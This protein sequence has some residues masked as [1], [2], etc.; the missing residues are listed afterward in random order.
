MKLGRFA[1][2]HRAG[3]RTVFVLAL[4]AS[5]F[6]SAGSAPAA[7]QESTAAITTGQQYFMATH[8]FNVFIGPNRRTSEPGPLDLLAAEAG[9]EGHASLGIQ[10]IGGSTPMQHWNQG[11]GDDGQNLAKVAL[12]AGGV[13]VFTMSP[14][15]LMPE[16]GIDLFGDLMIETNPQGRILVQNSWSAWDGN[17]TTGSVGGTGAAGF[18]NEDHNSATVET[19]QGWMDR[20]DAPGG[21]LER[22]R[23]QL[24]GINERAGR[25]MTYV[26]PS[27]FAVYRLRQEVVR[28]NVPGIELQ[29]E[30]FVDGMGHPNVPIRNLVSY[31]WFAS[32]YRQSPV[33]MTALVDPS[34]PTSAARERL[35]QGIAWNAVVSEAMSGVEGEPVML[36]AGR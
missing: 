34:D 33:G 22:M 12:R 15:A 17:G 36:S 11:N 29:S 19:I 14:N 28:G 5:G 24:A 35:L 7:A 23:T 9:L 3:A 10:M 1:R 30:I 16:E 2:W 4:L 32:M 13:D 27:S 8:S 20:L 18:T 26:V 6:F 21:Y 25:Q 31:V